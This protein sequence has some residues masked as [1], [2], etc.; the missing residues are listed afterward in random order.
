MQREGPVCGARRLL[1][2][3]CRLLCVWRR[4]LQVSIGNEGKANM[5]LPVRLLVEN[6][7]CA[8]VHTHT[9]THTH[10]QTC[11]HTHT[12]THA[13]THTHT[14]THTYTHTHTHLHPKKPEL[15][16]M[17]IC[18]CSQDGRCI[19]RKVAGQRCDDSSQCVAFA[20][21]SLNKRKC[22]CQSN[23]YEDEGACYP[24][25]GAGEPCERSECVR[26]S[27]WRRRQG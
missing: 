27:Q 7:E 26:F 1:V 15:T 25:I 21:C 3:L 24:A 13:H 17:S 4:L 10:T 19:A 2:R 5:T 9:H 6:P 22:V 16:G 8:R 14:H 11:T 18:V 12:H 23:F 20:E